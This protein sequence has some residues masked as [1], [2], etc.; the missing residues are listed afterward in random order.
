MK[1]K[2][3]GGRSAGTRNKGTQ[4]IKALLDEE[5]DFRELVKRLH[6]MSKLNNLSGFHSI[7]LLLA[8]RYGKPT[9]RI[10]LDYTEAEYEMLRRMA[11]EAME[12]L[13]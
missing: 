6:T 13:V 9:E 11:G 7:R 10:E 4:E 8:Y 3:T 5:V 2:K 1:G 12:K